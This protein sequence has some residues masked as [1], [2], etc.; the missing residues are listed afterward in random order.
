VFLEASDNDVSWGT[1]VVLSGEIVSDDPSCED[2]ELV[3]I[4]RRV[5]GRSSETLLAEV[6]TDANGFFAVQFRTRQSAVYRATAP[7]GHGCAEASSSGETIVV[8]VI[9]RIS[10]R[11][12]TPER[13]VRIRIMVSVTPNLAN[14]AVILERRRGS[15]FVEVAGTGLNDRSRA[16]FT[17]AAGW[18]GTRVFR[19]AWP[20]QDDDEQESGVSPTLAIRTHRPS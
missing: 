18:R 19:A 11:D 8:R 5:L 2:D 12:R 9:V 3:R 14:T 16:V 13:G 15:R 17:L 4:T 20:V 6:Q 1:G 10:T 7:A